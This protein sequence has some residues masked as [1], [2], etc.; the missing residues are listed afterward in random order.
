MEKFLTNIHHVSRVDN[1]IANA[2]S[3][4]PTAKDNKSKDINTK[5]HGHTNEVFTTGLREYSDIPPLEYTLCREN[6]IKGQDIKSLNLNI[7]LQYNASGHSS[8]VIDDVK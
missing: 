3:G 2:L 5:S 1:I 4:T 8:Q 7:Y 6:K